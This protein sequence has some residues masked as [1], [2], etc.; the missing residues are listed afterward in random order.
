MLST[1]DED[2][3]DIP[4]ILAMLSADTGIDDDIEATLSIADT[5]MVLMAQ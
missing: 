4:C 3:D 1:A 2:I 5:G